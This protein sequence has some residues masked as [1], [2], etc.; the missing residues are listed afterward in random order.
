MSLSQRS[1]WQTRRTDGRGVGCEP[2]CAACAACAVLSL[3][4]LWCLTTAPAK[5]NWCWEKQQGLGHK[6]KRAERKLTHYLPSLQGLLDPRFEK[7][8]SDSSS[9]TRL[10]TVL[11]LT[12]MPYG[13]DASILDV[14]V[15]LRDNMYFCAKR[16]RVSCL[17]VPQECKWDDGKC[18]PSVFSL[19][20]EKTTTAL[21][22]RKPTTA[23]P[24]PMPTASPTAN[25]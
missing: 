23:S 14:L 2:A 4:A 12:S 10:I 17:A 21:P 18:F 1:A 20:T 25:G 22:T 16:G 6:V 5:H 7:R 13:C 8:D 24:T 15:L 9:F 11:T 19:L 3:A